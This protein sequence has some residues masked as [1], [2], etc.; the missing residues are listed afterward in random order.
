MTE[1]A[2]WLAVCGTRCLAGFPSLATDPWCKRLLSEVAGPMQITR[3]N[4]DALYAPE[5]VGRNGL[6]WVF[7]D[8]SSLL[9]NSDVTTTL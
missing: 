3:R 7:A 6:K 9:A 2:Y 5:P 4:P 8:G 1:A